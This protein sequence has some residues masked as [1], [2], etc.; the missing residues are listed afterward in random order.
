MTCFPNDCC[1]TP[2][3]TNNM[4]ISGYGNRKADGMKKMQE[5]LARESNVTSLIGVSTQSCS[6]DRLGT[7]IIRTL[8][9]RF[10]NCSFFSS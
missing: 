9:V 1:A 10:R 2:R 8:F 7:K 4:T 6:A 5:K 3:T